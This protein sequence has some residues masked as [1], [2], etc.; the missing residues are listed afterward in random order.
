MA[1]ISMT[2]ERV[3]EIVNKLETSGAEIERIWNSVKTEEIPAI[4]NSWYG[5]DCDMYIQKILEMDADLQKA[6]Q[7][8]K[9]LANAFRN[10]QMQINDVQS[11][12]AQQVGRLG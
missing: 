12:I 4:Q 8:Q 9:L 3:S 2:S 6:L 7:A 1:L 10:A 11:N 5:K